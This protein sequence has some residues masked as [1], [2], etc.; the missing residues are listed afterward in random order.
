MYKEL[1]FPEFSEEILKQLKKGAFLTVKYG[2]RVNFMTIAWG[3]YGFM[4]NR[5]I[6]IVMVRHSRFTYELIDKADDFTVSFPLEGQLKKELSVCGTKSGRDVDK[7]IECNFK[8]NTSEKVTTPVIDGCD[9]YLECKIVYK[10]DMNE[11]SLNENMKKD[12]YSSGDYH[13]LYYGEVVRSYINE[14]H[15]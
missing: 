7:T 11:A 8:L 12:A 6:F 3:S 4:W 5:P 15:A 9:F 14:K 10:Q 2:D 13:V 1:N